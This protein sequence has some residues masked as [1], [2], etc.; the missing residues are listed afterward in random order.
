[1][2]AQQS[3][4]IQEV[5]THSTSNVDVQCVIAV[6]EVEALAMSSGEI[7][8]YFA[9]LADDAVFLPPSTTAKRGQELRL[10]LKDFLD[11]FGVQWLRFAHGETVV[12]GDLAYHE[13]E[14]SMMSTPR[15][16]GEPAISHGKGLHVL[17]R[18]PDGAWKVVRN[19]WNSVPAPGAK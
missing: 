13:Y 1:M 9:I 18:E 19:V 5:P 10:W 6:T 4:R 16:G 8:R 11:H 14:Y 3:R 15:T 17:R 7:D 2:T 12:A